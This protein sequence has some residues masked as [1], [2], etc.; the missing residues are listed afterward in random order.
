[1]DANSVW[2]TLQVVNSTT[3]YEIR[4][5]EKGGHILPSTL[6]E[7]RYISLQVFE[8]RV[9]FR[10]EPGQQRESSHSFTRSVCPRASEYA[11]P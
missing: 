8:A 7:I 5:L 9:S 1:M 2:L 4:T 3:T 6:L 10:Q 11:A